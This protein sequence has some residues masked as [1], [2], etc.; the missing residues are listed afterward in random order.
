VLQQPAAGD[1]VGLT[2]E[3]LPIAEAMAYAVV[4]GCGGLVSFVG[5]VRDFS[6]G[7]DGVSS[8]DYEAY[9]EHVVPRLEALCEAAR[10]RHPDAGRIVALHR[11]GHLEVTDAA[12]VVCASAPHR[13]EAFELAR[14]LIDTL[15]ATIP[16]W[17][18]ETWTGGSAWSDGTCEITDP[19]DASVDAHP[20][21]HVGTAG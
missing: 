3:A 10:G 9:P 6:D 12:V 16:I 13:A 4:P 19:T 15:K 5:T 18:R 2:D 14:Y 1:W 20:H 11:I 21:A 7:R 17:K 8:L